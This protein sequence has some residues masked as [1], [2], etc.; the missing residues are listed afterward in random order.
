MILEARSSKA[1]RDPDRTRKAILEAA[2]G[3]I[4]R[5]GFQGTRL[6][7]IVAATG[8]TKGALYHHFPNKRA[9]GYAVVEEVIAEQIHRIWLEPLLTAENPLQ[10][11]IYNVEHLEELGGEQLVTYGCPL[12]NLAQEMSPLDEGFRTRLDE[13]YSAWESGIEAALA[14]ARERG[15]LRS[16]VDTGQL[17]TFII[18]ALSG[19]IGL[20]KSAQS[21]ELLRDCSGGLLQY[22]RFLS[23]EAG[24]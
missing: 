9:L 7:D 19:C 24:Q 18:A 14:L 2:F 20:S 4:Y 3:E 12:N 15:Q 8:L 16:E 21:L 10:R 22:L 6:D 23:A 5:H 13:V 11:L 17:A 1:G